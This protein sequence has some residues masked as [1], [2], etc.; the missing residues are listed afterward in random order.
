[1]KGIYVDDCRMVIM[2]LKDGV[3]FYGKKFTVI[4]SEI[5]RDKENH[6]NR[7][8]R[9]VTEIRKAMNSISEDLTFTTELE[10]DFHDSR[11]PT[12]SFSLCSE[13]TGLRH[14][15]FEK[16]LQSQIMT[17]KRSS[18]SEQSKFNILVNELNRRFEVLDKDISLEERKNI[19]NHYTKQLVNS[20][21]STL[22]IKE[23]IESALKGVVRKQ[24]KKNIEIQIQKQ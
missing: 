2:K 17:M 15:Y 10:S 14:S 9:T 20:G 23:I 11:L 1:M 8:S 13:R 19:V 21:Y 22:Q 6:E 3:R 18:Q 24:E 7:D 5:L 16:S 12:L 4:E